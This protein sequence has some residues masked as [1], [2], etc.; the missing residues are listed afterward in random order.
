VH[1]QVRDLLIGHTQGLRRQ[2]AQ[3]HQRV[4]SAQIACIALGGRGQGGQ[5]Q[6][7]FR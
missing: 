6:F 3:R 2:R 7:E 5:I 1:L 4:C